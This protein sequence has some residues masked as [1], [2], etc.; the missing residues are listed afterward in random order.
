[1]SSVSKQPTIITSPPF[2]PL[3]WDGGTWQAFARFQSW[4]EFQAYRGPSGSRSSDASSDGVIRLSVFPPTPPFGETSSKQLPSPAQSDAYGRLLA[5]HGAVIKEI[6]QSILEDYNTVPRAVLERYGSDL[7]LVLHDPMQLQSLIGLSTVYFLSQV[8]AGAAYVGFQFD[9]QWD[10]E[11]GLGV[12]T[13]H[14]KVIAIG[15]A[16]VAFCPPFNQPSDS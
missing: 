10:W 8:H 15:Q 13:H 16:D 12:M 6:L 5:N 1:M 7:P 3:T 14:G 2:P 9:C 11:H 4:N